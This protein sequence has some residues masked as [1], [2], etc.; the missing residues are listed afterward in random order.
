LRLRTLGH[1]AGEAVVSVRD[2]SLLSIA[3]VSTVSISLLVLAIVTLLA[4]N[5][6]YMASV[7]NAQV[8]IVA[9]FQPG[10]GGSASAGGAGAGFCSSG[11]TSTTSS[12]AAAAAGPASSSAAAAGTAATG[13]GAAAGATPAGTGAT[14][15]GGAAGGT[16]PSGGSGFPAGASAQEA[17]VLAQIEAL[18]GVTRVQFISKDQALHNLAKELGGA[19][20]LIGQVGSENPLPDSADVYVSDP[21]LVAGVAQQVESMPGVTCV[22][23]AQ[24]MVNDLFGFTQALRYVGL[25]LVAAL[26]LTTLVVI[27]NTVRVAVYAR[28]DQI[29]IM[30]LV[31]ATD[32]FIRL[33]F[34]IEGA[35]LGVAGALL[36]GLLVAWGYGWL[37]RIAA[38]NIPFLPLVSPQ[39][40]TP[41]L[42]EALA[43]GGLL[44][45]ALGSAIS[46]RRHLNV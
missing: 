26:A 38:S 11:A 23:N 25:F 5:M 30:K 16:T 32:S 27:G 21:R 31:G 44:L 7:L 3:A 2:N 43:L 36:S 4:V 9:Y 46:V 41:R 37:H 42:I 35:I 15:A 34:F 1:L 39:A 6:Q 45:G 20:S 28:R 29:G 18:P 24:Q 14:S 10:T 13:A 17:A 40:L 19:P 22:Q 12:A 33:P 8:Q